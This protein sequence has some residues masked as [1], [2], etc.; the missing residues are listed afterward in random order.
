MK[1][2]PVDS[3]ALTLAVVIGGGILAALLLGRAVGQQN[4]FQ[5]VIV[6]GFVFGSLFFFTLGDRYWYL[7]PFALASGLP[8]IPL[9]G[10]TVELGELSIAACTAFFLTRIALKKDNLRLFRLTHVPILLFMGWVVLGFALNPTG[11]A[12]FG[13]ESGGGRFYLKLILA[14]CA[15]IIL[16]SQTLT[17]KDAKWIIWLILAGA[18]L[19]LAYGLASY[20]LLAGSSEALNPGAIESDEFYTWQQILAGPAITVAF[21]IFARYK[22]SEVMS[23]R[24]SWIFFG[25]ALTGV[26]A[27]ASGKRMGLVAVGLAP[28]VSSIIYRQ[29]GYIWFGC[30]VLAIFG[31]I[32]S[33]GQNQMFSLP[34]TMQRTLSWLPADWS[35]ELDSLQGGSDEFREALR[36]AATEK[37]MRHPIIGKGFTLDMGD[38]SAAVTEAM[39][40]GAIDVQ[41]AIY[42][43]GFS[44]HNTWLGYAADFGIPLSLIQAI[45]FLTVLVVAFRTASRLPHPSFLQT[46][47]IY[48]L[49]FA[50]RDILASHT[51]GHTSTDAF[52]RWWMYGLVFSVFAEATVKSKPRMQSRSASKNDA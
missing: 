3:R 15:F 48:I 20:F 32:V 50:C 52:N 45:L 19:K 27:L 7:I 25:Y 24:R 43:L 8:A 21:L 17:E 11:L 22:P 23:L 37:I 10:R 9:G 38:A 47:I 46:L 40:G 33:L 36:R 13:A 1:N 26:L 34:L 18:L 12:F 39:H 49:I 44:W 30:I 5:I 4:Y 28:F 2:Q 6:C 51:S 41:V 29:R 14:F 16:A 35:P 31:S 42:A